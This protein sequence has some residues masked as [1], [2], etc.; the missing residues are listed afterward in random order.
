MDNYDYYEEH[1]LT[2]KLSKPQFSIALKD[3]CPQ[4]ATCRRTKQFYITISI[5][6]F[7]KNYFKLI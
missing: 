1:A 5:S 4:E 3:Y 2:E 6:A 7:L